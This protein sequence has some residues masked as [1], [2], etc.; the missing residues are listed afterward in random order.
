MAVSLFRLL[1]LFLL[2]GTGTSESA[3][4]RITF[5]GNH[6]YSNSRLSRVIITQRKDTYLESKV[7]RDSFELVYFYRNQGYPEVR[8]TPQYYPSKKKLE[9]GIMEGRRLR[10]DSVTIVGVPDEDVAEIKNK[11]PL[12]KGKPLTKRAL[13]GTEKT[14]KRYY[15]DK[16]YPYVV[17]NL[18]TLSKTYLV[19]LNLSIVPGRKIWLSSITFKGING[20]VSPDFLFRTIKIKPGEQYSI[21][22][23]DR[24]SRLLYTTSL[25]SR[26]EVNFS[27]PKSGN[28][29]SLDLIYKLTRQKTRSITLGAGIQTDSLT[30][31]PDRLL[32][33]AGWENLNLFHRGISLSAEFTYNPKFKIQYSPFKFQGID[34]DAM[35]NIKNT[36]PK[37]LPLGLDFTLSPYIE[38]SLINNSQNPATLIFTIGGEAGIKKDFSNRLVTNLS[39]Q[40]KRSWTNDTSYYS[41]KFSSTNFMRLSIIFDSRNDF[42]NPSSGVFLYSFADWAGNPFGGDNNFIRLSSDFRNYLAL[43]FR[44]VLAWRIKAGL[45]LPHSGQQATDIGYLEK[46]SLGGAGTIRAFAPYSFGPDSTVSGKSVRYFGTMLMVNNIELRTPYFFDLVGLD[47]F[48]DLGV[49][50]RNINLI[51]QNDWGWGPGLG[52]RVSTPIGPVRLD[53]AKNGA[54]P[55]L[56]FKESWTFGGRLEFGFMHAF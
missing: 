37:I 6:H 30:P 49:C 56:P 25:F 54:T 18:D 27:I 46:F 11:I 4:R 14:T 33:T 16:G 53:Y 51:N 9:F 17:V 20:F 19:D 23:L 31:Q 48:L 45:L 41:K 7:S 38:H 24:A 34:Y 3:I 44:A 39:M 15:Q 36:Y 21:S 55:F 43:P 12:K 28:Q 47:L 13:A 42:F 29:D 5:K 32:L 35:L 40:V 22:K 10:I 8:V 2:F 1:V 26:V 52:I 50:S